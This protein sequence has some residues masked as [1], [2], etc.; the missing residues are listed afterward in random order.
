M[1]VKTNKSCGDIENLSILRGFAEAQE[2]Q[3]FIG[4]VRR[5]IS[6]Y[7]H[8]HEGI[9]F[10]LLKTPPATYRGGCEI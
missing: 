9:L 2:C 10:Q 6:V 4:G 8:L 3:A 5:A 7:I 1:R